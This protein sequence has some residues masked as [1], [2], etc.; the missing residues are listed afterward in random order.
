MER[1]QVGSNNVSAG[2][3]P[4]LDRAAGNAAEWPTNETAC[5]SKG[6]LT[7]TTAGNHRSAADAATTV[8]VDRR[9]HLDVATFVDEYL[10][11]NRPVLFGPALTRHW[12]VFS[13]WLT[14]KDEE[15][16]GRSLDRSEL[17]VDTRLDD[18]QKVKT[19]PTLWQPNF[20]WLQERFG[21]TTVTVTEC[22]PLYRDSSD[23]SGT[24][25]K[26]ETPQETWRTHCMAFREFV[27]RWQTGHCLYLKDWH[28]QRT[29]PDEPLYTVPRP[30]QDD[31]LN[32][33]WD[34][35]TDVEDD[36]R[37][38]YMGGDRTWTPM[39][40]DVF[41]CA[42]AFDSPGALYSED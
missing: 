1:R 8:V 13:R 28:F 12:P 18:I 19:Q 17:P 30:F 15:E 32:R 24:R 20:S 31:W 7:E 4:M 40:A 9:T 16:K 36:Y 14:A 41:R 39:H 23:T 34:Q 2:C 33:F 35:R 42:D 6:G 11:P 5:V 29:F 38:V 26:T 3:V 22:P 27:T 37:F 25:Q 21:D 10:R